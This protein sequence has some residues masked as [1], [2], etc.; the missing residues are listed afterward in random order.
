MNTVPNAREQ[1]LPQEP[2]IHC[3]LIANRGE[4]AVRIIRAVHDLGWRAVAVYSDSDRGALHTELADSAICL[5]GDSAA[6]SYLDATK[7]I[8]AAQAGGAQAVHPGYGFLSE[9]ADFA[10]ACATAGLIFIGPSPQAIRL[11]GDKRAAK[12]SV[13][14]VSVPCIPGYDDADQTDAALL[15]AGQRIGVPLM[16]KAAAGG[17]GRGMRMVDDLAALPAAITAARLEATN[18][19]GNGDLLLEQAL[20]ESRH[21]EVQIVADQQGN[22]VHL[23]ER[24]C[25]LQR[26]HQKVIEEAPSPFVDATLR[27]R[28]GGA[29]IAAARSCNYVGLGTVEFLVAGDGRFAFLEMNTRLQVEHPVTEMVTG[30]DLVV[31][32]LKIAA[33]EPLGFEQSQIELR[34]HAIEARL[35]AEDPATGFAPQ[36]GA[37]LRWQPAS[38]AGI[39]VD[40]GL[41]QE[42][43]ITA[44][45][46]PMIAKL[47]G[48]ADSRGTAIN[49]L[50]RCLEDTQLLGLK[51]NQSFLVALL[52]DRVFAKGQATTDYIDQRMDPSRLSSGA[53]SSESLALATLALIEQQDPQADQMRY[54]SNAQPLPRTRRLRVGSR[55]IIAVMIATNAGV[56]I[57]LSDV[58][59]PDAVS[60]KHR[61]ESIGFENESVSAQVDGIDLSRQYVFQATGTQQCP[62]LYLHDSAMQ[63]ELVDI[64][65]EPAQRDDAQSSGQVAAT[66]EGQIVAIAIDAGARVAAG[67]LLVVVEAMKM[68]HR[69]LAP[70]D[71]VVSEITARL[72]R[73]V[74]KGELLAAITPESIPG[75]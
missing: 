31:L 29:A 75:E 8:R 12:R 19:F 59:D 52:R 54:W 66:T 42:D 13:A 71:G 6:D 1:I 15:A 55:E 18:A 64:T 23:G 21:I 24:D 9:N 27:E 22:T 32:Q 4:I 50:T 11:M 46:D 2:T 10:Q 20:F 63:T 51:T 17:G 68:A 14:A 48:H 56:T 44:F 5:G 37:I 61:L 36:T 60:I 70:I 38:G 47:I 73:Q 65:Y 69:H 62:M 3:V 53:I 41:H 45:F 43:R 30:I 28:L 72:D 16:V 74:K 33:G 49:R 34:G 67:D 26:K 35:Y 39:R 7:V 40:H 58:N 57:E 25:S